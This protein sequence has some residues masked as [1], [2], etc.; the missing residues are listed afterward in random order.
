MDKII[1]FVNLTLEEWNNLTNKEKEIIYDNMRIHDFFNTTSPYEYK[2]KIHENLIFEAVRLRDINSFKLLYKVYPQFNPNKLNEFDE[3]A[4]VIAAKG[5]DYKLLRYLIMNCGGHINKFVGTLEQKY[6][7]IYPYTAL[8]VAD[9]IY[10]TFK[11]IKYPLRK[12]LVTTQKNYNK[13]K[14]LKTND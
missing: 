5:R 1:N 6:N 3:S 7:Q 8:E 2:Q 10:G 13:K 14:L 4:M 11:R 12:M 9:N